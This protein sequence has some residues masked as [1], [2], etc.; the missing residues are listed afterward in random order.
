[1]YFHLTSS[2]SF[3]GRWTSGKFLPFPCLLLSCG[4]VQRNRATRF[5]WWFKISP[6]IWQI[7]CWIKLFLRNFSSRY[8][9]SHKMQNFRP[10]LGVF[11]ICGFGLD[12]SY[13]LMLW[14]T[15]HPCSNV[16]I[17]SEKWTVEKN[18]FIWTKYKTIPMFCLKFSRE[19]GTFWI[20]PWKTPEKIEV[21]PITPNVQERFTAG[22]SRCD[23]PVCNSCLEVKL[24]NLLVLFSVK[25][26]F[27]FFFPHC[28]EQSVM[29]VAGRNKS[30]ILSLT[31]FVLFPSC[32]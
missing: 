20:A 9:L 10:T 19:I 15:S 26:F 28:P 8:D 23:Y 13:F 24:A 16:Q 29:C 5:G 3:L 18:L 22:V 11:K 30:I 7:Q 27:F 4:D 14:L 21:W 12:P 17:G 32:F 25:L 1:M 2:D 6:D 31:A